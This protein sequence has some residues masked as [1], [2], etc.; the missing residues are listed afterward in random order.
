ASMYL[1][2]LMGATLVAPWLHLFQLGVALD[3]FFCAPARETD[4]ETPVFIVAFDADDGPDAVTRM[5]NFLAE[6]RVCIGAAPGGR[7]GERARAGGPA[8][9][10]GR[11]R[12]TSHTAEE[13]LR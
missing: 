4:G 12:L 1:E 7:P 5:A 13:F 8:R 10:G 3:E 9:R 2:R 11:L 6:K